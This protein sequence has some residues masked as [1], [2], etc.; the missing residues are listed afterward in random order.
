MRLSILCALLFIPGIA[1]PQ[2]AA[3]PPLTAEDAVMLAVRSNPGLSASAR[4]V[5]AA[6]SGPRSARA[7]S[8][9]TFTFTPGLT[10]V[11]GSGDEL[12]LSQPL[13]LNGTRDARAGVA[14]AQ[15]QVTQAEAVGE[16]R[17]LVFNTKTAYCQLAQ[18]R[19]MQSLARDTLK[20]AEEFDRITRLLVEAGKRPGIELSQT[21]IEVIRA[22][23]QVTLAGGQETVTLAA[24][25]TLMARAAGTPI[26]KVSTF[27]PSMEVV[28]E[29]LLIRQALASRAEV[30]GA[31]AARD[32]FQRQARLARAEGRPDLVPQV[33]FGSLVRGV[34]AAGTGNGFGIGLGITLPIFD[35]GS[36]RNRIRQSEEAARA[37]TD[38]ITAMQNQVRQ[39]VT[40]AV[41]RLRAA[42]TVARDYQQGIL[43]RA[44]RLLDASGTGF[45]EGQTSVIN[46]LEAQR[47]YRAVQAEYI[48]AQV[49]QAQA[50]AELERAS[51][52]VPASLLPSIP[53]EARR[54]K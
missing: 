45:L 22:R 12:I 32:T 8:N 13:E 4:D 46:V 6:R 1:L 54:N 38:R 52:A 48:E 21:G 16:L 40:Q 31:E 49:K 42:Q 5:A 20:V 3:P 27:S 34:S 41:A 30:A 35:Y 29:A 7:L 17:S 39:E 14:N 9:P 53:G 28:D 10:S 15:L 44:R 25:N 50:Q 2:T 23:Q 37:Q 18:A 43:D 26:G 24:L 11:S 19:E 33:R 36:R 51:G 47:T